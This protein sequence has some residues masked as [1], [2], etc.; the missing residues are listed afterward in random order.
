MKRL[1]IRG[2]RAGAAAVLAT[3]AVSPSPAARHGAAAEGRGA[4]AEGGDAD[5]DQSPGNYV[6]L[7][8]QTSGQPV[9][10]AQVAQARQQAA[11]ISTGDSTSWQFVGPTNV[12]GR[13]VDLAVD[14][15]TSPS[16]V[17]AAVSSGGDIENNAGGVTRTPAGPASAPPAAGALPPRPGRPPWAGPPHPDPRRGGRT[18]P[19]G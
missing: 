16:T 11:S 7:L 1:A 10:P 12:G 2:V 4:A 13:V 8:K 5:A 19:A 17:Y 18:R 15:T 14:P 6:D 9:T 3:Y